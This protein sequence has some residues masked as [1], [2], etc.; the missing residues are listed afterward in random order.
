MASIHFRQRLCLE[1]L[2]RNA[3]SRSIRCI[4][5]SWFSFTQSAFKILA[6]YLL[7]SM[8]RSQPALARP[9]QESAT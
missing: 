9:S 5:H 2:F 3:K 4:A 8:G 1:R 7:C 6:G